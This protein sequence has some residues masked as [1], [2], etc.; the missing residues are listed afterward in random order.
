MPTRERRRT[1]TARWLGASLAAAILVLSFLSL[2]AGVAAH[3]TG[4]EVLRGVLAACGLGEPLESG[5]LVLE[6]RLWRTLV[7]IAVGAALALSGGLLQGL[8]RNAL[9]S[10]SV[11]GVTTGSTLGAYLGTLALGGYIPLALPEGS[12]LLVPIVVTL[13]AFAG[14]LGTGAFVLWLGS[15]GGR[16]SVP[17]LLLVGLAV[18][19]CIGGVLAVIQSRSID[20]YGLTRAFL[21]WGFGTLDDRGPEQALMVWVGTLL[22]A[23]VIPLVAFELDLFAGGEDDARGLGVSTGRVKAL[24]LVGAT[25]A[26]ASAVAVAGQISFVGLMIPHLVRLVV[27]SAHRRVLPLSLLAGAVL[28]LGADVSQRLLFAGG[29]L[30]PGVLMSLFGGPFFLLLLVRNRRMIE[31]W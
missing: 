15:S 18:N 7:A 30:E 20:D 10:P 26:A 22:A 6:L 5:Q 25:L 21:S 1:R 17:A 8:F 4:G 24:A 31:S 9:A 23:A 12:A 3:F 28:L 11:L 2:R 27:G 19:T 29:G 16:L 14:A 13:S